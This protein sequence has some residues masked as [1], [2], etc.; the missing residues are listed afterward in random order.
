MRKRLNPRCKLSVQVSPSRPCVD[1][2]VS[3]GQRENRVGAA[4]FWQPVGCWR[5]QTMSPARPG[6]WRVTSDDEVEMC[7][8]RVDGSASKDLLRKAGGANQR[9]RTSRL[10]PAEIVPG[11]SFCPHRSQVGS[12]DCATFNDYALSPTLSHS[13]LPQPIMASCGTIRRV[14]L[15]MP[16]PPHHIGERLA[17][18]LHPRPGSKQHPTSFGSDFANGGSPRP[19]QIRKRAGL[20]CLPHSTAEFEC[21]SRLGWGVLVGPQARP[22]RRLAH[23][24]NAVSRG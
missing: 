12:P 7:C 20:S 4:A 22:I 1:I 14:S 11:S 5:K 23:S 13:P 17:A 21:A 19:H 6:G 16:E 2:K 15:A 8:Q 18:H 9:A 3:L 24:R 10:P